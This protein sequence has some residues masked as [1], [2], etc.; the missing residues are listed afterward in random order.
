[1]HLTVSEISSFRE[2]SSVQFVVPA[3]LSRYVAV[4]DETSSTLRARAVGDA[5]VVLKQAKDPYKELTYFPVS[6]KNTQ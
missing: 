6:V 2:D 4:V 1:M 5:A 3:F